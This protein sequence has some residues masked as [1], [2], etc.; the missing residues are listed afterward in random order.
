MKG[1]RALGGATARRQVDGKDP[2]IIV[3]A[4]KWPALGQTTNMPPDRWIF[5]E[6]YDVVGNQ[7]KDWRDILHGTVRD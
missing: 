2:H 6:I 3:I 4:N 7:D 1:M 5:K